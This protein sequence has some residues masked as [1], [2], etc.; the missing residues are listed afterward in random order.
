MKN[1]KKWTRVQE[2]KRKTINDL[3][4]YVEPEMTG[5]SDCWDPRG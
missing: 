2:L 4:N 5:L 1:I 3:E